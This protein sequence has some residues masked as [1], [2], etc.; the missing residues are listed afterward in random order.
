MH[1]GGCSKNT[2][3]M[4]IGKPTTERPLKRSRPRWEDN[5]RMNFK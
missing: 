4:L 5:I 2:S 3:K 1:L